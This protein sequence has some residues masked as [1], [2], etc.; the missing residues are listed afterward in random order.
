MGGSEHIDPGLPQNWAD[1]VIEEKLG[2]GSYGSVYSAVRITG[3]S[4]THCAIKIVEIPT[5]EEEYAE[6]IDTCGSRANADAYLEDLAGYYKNEV[7]M[8]YALKDQGHV[9][10]IYDHFIAPKP[11]GNGWS[12]YI[13]MELLTGFREYF[14]DREIT[15]EDVI[16]VGCDICD[17]LTE[18][19]EA[20]ILHRDIKADNIFS[21]E[22]GVFKLGDFGTACRN[23]NKAQKVGG[24][25]GT[26]YYMAPEVLRGDTGDIR[27]DIYSLGLVLY[28]MLNEE[29]D[30]FV[31]T[32]KQLIYRKDREEAL[33]RRSAGEKIPAP[34][35]GSQQLDHIVL[36][37]C[38]HSPGKRYQKPE[39]M[40]ADLLRCSTGT[41]REASVSRKRKKKRLGGIIAGGLAVIMVFLAIL[42]LNGIH[43]TA[44]EAGMKKL[45]DEIM[46]YAGT[47]FEAF[48]NLFGNADQ[49]YVKEMN[50][51]F[52]SL[53]QYDRKI[54]VPITEEEE[55]G[56]FSVIWYR[57]DY[58]DENGK[59]DEQAALF[60]IS[61]EGKDWKIENSSKNEEAV[62][63]EAFSRGMQKIIE[64]AEDNTPD[65]EN[66]QS[67]QDRDNYMFLDK[68]FTYRNMIT[69][70]VRYL[71]KEEAG[72]G[73]LLWI[74]N[75]TNREITVDSVNVT[76]ADAGMVVDPVDVKISET[77]SSGAN[78]LIC[79]HLNQ[80]NEEAFYQPCG[81]MTGN[82]LRFDIS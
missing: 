29:R 4:E 76:D 45:T 49:K 16:T 72:I 5:D 80:I 14:S 71:W 56:L 53:S 44:A 58:V 57:S 77:V 37:A 75:G 73:C 28:K 36:K 1:W 22:E 33:K 34:L 27:S 32:S 81:N 26:I 66:I 51:S 62:E 48:S 64:A 41:D 9:A 21:S 60:S 74:A 15:E 63:R 10:E 19:D 31:D 12:I 2:E 11:S 46:K 82:I 3:G 47:D 70:E 25:Q 68:G 20:G 30:P 67:S 59:P 78:R 24:K 55:S 23:T 79:L 65:P 52:S 17:A 61:K 13:C 69:Y 6:L 50:S 35:H 40:K 54:I 18:C 43:K 39:Q 42:F 38:E 8:M 7:E